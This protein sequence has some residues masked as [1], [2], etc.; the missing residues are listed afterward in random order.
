V[1]IKESKHDPFSISVSRFSNQNF[2]KD[3]MEKWESDE[4][5]W[6]DNKEILFTDT[7]ND[8]TQSNQREEKTSCLINGQMATAENIR[9]YL[10]LFDKLQIILP[11][12]SMYLDFINSLGVTEEE[13]I[14]LIEL[15][16]VKLILP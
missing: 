6:S 3:L 11:I 1:Q 10:T 5:I 4:Q 14:K 12:E 7:E 13:L 8:K 9:N 2:S 16:K 15:G